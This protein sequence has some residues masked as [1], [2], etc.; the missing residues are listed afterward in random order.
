MPPQNSE[1]R[2]RQ[3]D[4]ENAK[5]KRERN[6]MFADITKLERTLGEFEKPRTFTFTDPLHRQTIQRNEELAEEVEAL[7]RK[8]L[9]AKEENMRLKRVC[10]RAENAGVQRVEAKRKRMVDED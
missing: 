8:L 2:G 10:D 9:A 4:E 3:L 1:K 5:L 6:T 7:E